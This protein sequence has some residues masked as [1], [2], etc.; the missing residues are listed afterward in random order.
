MLLICYYIYNR[1]K[2]NPSVEYNVYGHS[3]ELSANVIIMGYRIIAYYPHRTVRFIRCAYKRVI[4]YVVNAINMRYL[5][6]IAFT[7]NR[8]KSVHFV[9]CHVN[10][11]NL[12]EKYIITIRYRILSASS[13]AVRSML[14]ICE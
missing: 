2:L 13:K 8:K 7:T 3:L 11:I 12:S 6:L 10:R 5:I 9:R 14:I 4:T 1:Q